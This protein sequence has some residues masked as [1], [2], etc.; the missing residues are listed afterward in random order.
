VYR[1][2]PMFPWAPSHAL[3]VTL[4]DFWNAEVLSVAR[5]PHTE[6]LEFSFILQNVSDNSFFCAQSG[7]R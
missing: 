6:H 3:P 1:R 2:T 4:V 5:V 7:P